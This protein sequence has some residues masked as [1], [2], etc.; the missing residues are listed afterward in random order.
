[1]GA[2]LASVID[3]L[4]A[5]GQAIALEN[6]HITRVKIIP[7]ETKVFNATP[8]EGSLVEPIVNGSA[9]RVIS[10]KYPV[11]RVRKK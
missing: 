4:L 10:T 6:P 8:A 2:N 11:I 1:M 7:H 3:D 9:P 5:V